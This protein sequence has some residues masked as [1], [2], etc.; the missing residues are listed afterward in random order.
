M[1]SSFFDLF[2]IAS[3]KGDLFQG[4]TSFVR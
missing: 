3:K 1:G 2:Q 4:D